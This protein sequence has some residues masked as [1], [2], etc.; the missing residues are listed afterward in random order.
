[1]PIHG[2]ANWSDDWYYPRWTGTT[3]RH[4]LGLDMFAP[5][6]TPVAAP[7]DGVARITENA[8][9]GLTVRVVQPDG[10]FW[11]LAHLSGIAAGVIDGSPVTMG[12]EVGYVGDSGNA[13]GGSPHLHFAV[14]PRGGAPVPP[15]PIVDAMVADGAARV[16]DLLA[17]TTSAQS[18]AAVVAT[19]LTRRLADGVLS[20]PRAASGPPRSELL[21][22]SAANPNGG[23]VAVADAAAASLNEAVDW[24]QRAAEQRSLDLA[25]TQARDR[26]WQ[27]VGPLAHPSLRRLLGA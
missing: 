9:G 18:S 15:K 20:G 8:L 4:H 17:Q 23:A 6:G 19:D 5:F 1:F 7:A 11:Y 24:E 14:H 22:A 13:R 26:A 21:W 3:F 10:T 12:Q 25:W 16:V 27:L 2:P